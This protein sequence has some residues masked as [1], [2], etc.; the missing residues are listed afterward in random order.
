MGIL[1]PK[2][3][4]AMRTF[5]LDLRAYLIHQLSQLMCGTNLE[6]RNVLTM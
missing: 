6:L 4:L 3:H 2:D 1:G 5:Y